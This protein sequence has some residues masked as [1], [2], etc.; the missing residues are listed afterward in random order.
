MLLGIGCDVVH[1]MF[2]KKPSK[3]TPAP[4]QPGLRWKCVAFHADPVNEKNETGM[5][6]TLQS[7]D[8]FT[9]VVS[10]SG[11]ANSTA[12]GF[13]D[14]LRVAIARIAMAAGGALPQGASIA[15]NVARH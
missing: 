10:V 5:H 12:E 6:F 1:A 4:K 9:F 14:A 7:E 13:I 15:L 3:P 11:D 2:K 8:G